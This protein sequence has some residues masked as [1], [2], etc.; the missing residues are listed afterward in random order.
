M[1]T[2]SDGIPPEITL[3]AGALHPPNPIHLW[4]WS[5]QYMS[6]LSLI[7]DEE[8]FIERIEQLLAE[9]RCPRCKGDLPKNPWGSL[10]APCRC[11]PL[12]WTC[13]ADELAFGPLPFVEDLDEWPDLEGD[14]VRFFFDHWIRSPEMVD[15]KAAILERAGEVIDA[16]LLRMEAD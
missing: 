16:H 8:E 7:D 14:R 9:G 13:G 3:P 2:P 12:C 1:T 11:I 6:D 15:Q 4:E 10:I 5:C